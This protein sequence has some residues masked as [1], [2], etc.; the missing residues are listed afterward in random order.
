MEQFINMLRLWMN[1]IR[2]ANLAWLRRNFAAT[3]PSPQRIRMWRWGELAERPKFKS[4]ALG[5]ASVC[6]NFRPPDVQIISH[7]VPSR[8]NEP[9]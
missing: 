9:V 7:I 5:A 2:S 4:Y 3:R 8:E 1:K 6:R